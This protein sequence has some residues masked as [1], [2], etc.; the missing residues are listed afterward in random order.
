MLPSD[1]PSPGWDQAPPTTATPFERFCNDGPD[2]GSAA[3]EFITRA[4]PTDGTSTAETP[5]LS[6]ATPF[7][8]FCNDGPDKGSAVWEFIR[9]GP[10]N[11][12]SA[13]RTPPASQS[14]AART[15]P[16]SQST[17]AAASLSQGTREL[18][19]AYTKYHKDRLRTALDG[20]S[21]QLP[22]RG[23]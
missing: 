4:R 13:A 23:A 14:T 16:P 17:S 12:T 22:P 20:L 18:L 7:E 3:W 21:S 11:G 15:P 1:E 9:A 19:G 5:P 2:K 6:T 8:R 10:T